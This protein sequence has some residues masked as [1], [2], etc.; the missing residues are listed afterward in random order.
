V[1]ARDRERPIALSGPVWGGDWGERARV[2]F[3]SSEIS[4]YSRR[5]APEI[6]NPFSAESAMRRAATLLV[7]SRAAVQR[8]HAAEFGSIDDRSY[9]L[10]ASDVEQ[11]GE[12][13]RPR[14]GT[15]RRDGRRRDSPGGPSHHRT[16]LEG[17]RLLLRALG[18][19]AG[20]GLV[21]LRARHR[22][23]RHGRRRRR[24]VRD[25]RSGPPP[26]RRR[27]ALHPSARSHTVRNLGRCESRWL[28][29]Y[30]R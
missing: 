17:A 8:G 24:R 16:S 19:S 10:S 23:A 18:R 29:G 5:A 25:R 14:D 20:P 28:Y 2:P 11:R 6:S 1:D 13:G 4:F 3:N 7:I 9:L 22:R 26:R 15:L 21:R 12:R 30:R 27:G